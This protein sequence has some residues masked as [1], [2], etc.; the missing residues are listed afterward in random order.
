MCFLFLDEETF[1]LIVLY[2]YGVKVS[3]VHIQINMNQV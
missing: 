2:S 1:K 3:F